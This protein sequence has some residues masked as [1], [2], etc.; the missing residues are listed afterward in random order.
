MSLLSGHQHIGQLEK[1]KGG[2]FFLRI[3]AEEVTSF[4]RGK[5]T[6]LICTLDDEVDIHCGLNHMGDGDFFLIVSSKYVKKLGKELGAE[7]AYVIKEDPNPLGVEIPEVLEALLAQDPI[8][9]ESWE[10]FTD[11]RKRTLIYTIQ[12]IK[13]FDKQVK[14][15]VEFIEE[16]E[17]KRR[18]K[19]A[20][21]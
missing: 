19:L 16:E 8:I 18:K 1:R 11:G 6:R 2:Y 10:R 15:V 7:V 21:S 3:S 9:K 20:K 17:R 12:R 5:K 14:A 4:P 13:D